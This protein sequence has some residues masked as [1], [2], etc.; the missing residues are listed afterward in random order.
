MAGLRIKGLVFDMYGTLVD[1][2]AVAEACKEVPPGRS[3]ERNSEN[4]SDRIGANRAKAALPMGDQR[5]R[6]EAVQ[7]F[8]RSVSAG[9]KAH[10]TTEERD[11]LCLLQLLRCGG[12]QK[13]RLQGVL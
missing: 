9:A 13:L 3:V 2:G 7:A 11:P 12:V 4:A 1:V 6:R 5:G 10:A 8:A